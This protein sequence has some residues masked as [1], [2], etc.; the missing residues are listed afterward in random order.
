VLSTST[1]TNNHTHTLCVPT[2]D[3][4]TPPAAGATYTT[5]SDAGHNHTVALTQQQLQSINSGGSVT[6]T[7]SQPYAH[8]FTIKKA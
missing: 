3:L 5:S 6:V 4:T 2:T 8:D 7:S 1:V